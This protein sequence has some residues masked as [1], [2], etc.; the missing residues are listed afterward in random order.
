MSSL[1]RLKTP[2]PTR[3]AWLS[4]E[5]GLPPLVAQILLNRGID[6]AAEAREFL[7]CRRTHL[8]DPERLPGA[9]SA[10][11]RIMRAVA[12]DRKIVI[13]GD[14]DVDGVCGTTILWSCLKLAG[15]RRL[16]YYIPHRVEEGYGVNADSLRRLRAEQD[17]D[18]VIT[19]DCGITAIGEAALARELG[20]ELIITDHHTLGSSLPE[21]DTIV[22]PRL[23]GTDYPF[24]ELCGAGVAFKLA[25]QIAKGFGDG[26]KAS[27]V[28]RDYLVKAMGLVALAT[29]ADLVPIEG[30]NRVF[31]RYGLESISQDPGTGLT[32][33]MRAAGCLGKRLTSGTVGFRLGPRINAAGR[34]ERA[35]LA[36]ELLTTQDT[37]RAEDLA[38]ELESCNA[39]RQEIERA[40]VDEARHMIDAAGGS[41]GRGALVVGHSNWH[42]GVIGIVA[43][44]LVEI[45]HRP[46]IVVALGES[47][48]Q[49][50]GR[51]I[52]GFDLYSAIKEC[53]DGLIGFGG[54]RAAAGVRFDPAHF[55]AFAGRFD[56]HCRAVLTPEQLRKVVSIDAEVHLG[57]LD[58]K[59]V[60][61]I[62]AMEP[63]GI[64][65]PQPVLVAEDVILSAAPRPVG[66]QAQHLQLRFSQ[67]TKAIKAIAFNM[68]ERFGNLT[69][70]ARYSILFTPSI[71]EWQDR[72]EVQLEIKDVRSAVHATD[73]ASA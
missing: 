17:G 16:D 6:S 40:I 34:M 73:A 25:W 5:A 10:A 41:T 22:H 38:I 24:P 50:S 69:P 65:N 29:V 51:S 35:M 27:P 36:V 53:S 31:V 19:V 63:H 14:Y 55:D 23:P 45:Y 30:E 56:Q 4:R 61:Q 52:P 42:P 70:G 44:R 48:A 20:I 15:A 13:Y 2:D 21:A 11:E 66:P 12:E 57:M 68:A 9:V 49:G 60:E 26:K 72:R 32:A 47:L 46:T 33:L 3:V 39:R 59:T 1:W 37:D 58:L 64:G 67:G 18:L 62:G 8:I 71:N 54:H 28:L 43:S 7:D